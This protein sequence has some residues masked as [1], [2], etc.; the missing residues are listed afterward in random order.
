MIPHILKGC[1]AFILKAFHFFS[2]KMKALYT[3][4]IS[5]PTNK[6]NLGYFPDVLK[7]LLVLCKNIS[8]EFLCGSELIKYLLQFTE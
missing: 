2:L 8:T 4:K 6:T 7:P 5:E 3:F 1:N